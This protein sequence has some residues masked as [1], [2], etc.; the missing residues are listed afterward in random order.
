MA[1]VTLLGFMKEGGWTMWP[2]LIFGLVCVGAAVHFARR[3]SGDRLACVGAMWLTVLCAAAHGMITDAA[4][5]FHALA[6]PTLFSDSQLVRVLFV[7][8]K[9]ASR[10]GALAGIFLTLGALV[11]TIGLF[12]GRPV[13]TT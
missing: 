1:E 7:G 11:V 2:I 10:P 4:A 13:E 8:L 12:R 6:D 3:P 9:E 5:V